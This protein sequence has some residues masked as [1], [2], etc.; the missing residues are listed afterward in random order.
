MRRYQSSRTSEK[1]TSMGSSNN[2]YNINICFAV[3]SWI[4]KRTY[5]QKKKTIYYLC[6]N[7]VYGVFLGS[8]L[9]CPFAFIK[10]DYSLVKLCILSFNIN[11]CKIDFTHYYFPFL[12]MLRKS[13]KTKRKPFSNHR[14]QTNNASNKISHLI[15]YFATCLGQR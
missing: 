12:N 3:I 5:L 4:E 7:Y 11:F 10:V 9:R 13:H 8:F 2:F 1:L 15:N 14:K 6:S